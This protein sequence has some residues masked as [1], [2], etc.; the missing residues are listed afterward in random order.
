MRPIGGYLGGAAFRVELKCRCILVGGD[1]YGQ[2][3]AAKRE[4][5]I[6]VNLKKQR[7]PP[8]RRRGALVDPK[9]PATRAEFIY[10]TRP[11]TWP[12]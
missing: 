11:L 12:A 8:R 2:L 1:T 5:Y 6:E 3:G 4:V 7:P 10:L 9:I